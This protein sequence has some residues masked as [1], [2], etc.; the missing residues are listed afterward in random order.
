MNINDIK[1][2]IQLLKPHLKEEFGVSEIGVFGSWVKGTQR[3]GSDV[4]I[5]VSFDRSITLFGLYDLQ[6]FLQKKIRRKVDVVVKEGLKE[7]IGNY[8]LKEVE[9][10]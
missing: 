3:R 1:H 2:K 6:D 5:L 10:V 7:S 8:I 4:D 9:Y